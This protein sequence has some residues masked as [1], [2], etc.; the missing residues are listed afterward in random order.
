[1]ISEEEWAYLMHRYPHEKLRHLVGKIN[2]WGQVSA[3]CSDPPKPIRLATS[4][5]VMQAKYVT[6]KKC[7]A[8]LKERGVDIDTYSVFE[9]N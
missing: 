4:G 9:P 1:L 5:W 8:I 2:S 3:L 6:C 7:L